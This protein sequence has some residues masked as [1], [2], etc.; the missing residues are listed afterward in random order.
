MK[1]ERV[2]DF[3]MSIVHIGPTKL[4]SNLRRYDDHRT[5]HNGPLSRTPNK[6]RNQEECIRLTEEFCK[7]PVNHKAKEDKLEVVH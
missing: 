3:P 6:W 4:Q 2:T 7:L 1:M 5:R